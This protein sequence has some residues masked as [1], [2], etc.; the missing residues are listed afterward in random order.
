[1]LPGK[2]CSL[3]HFACRAA[4]AVCIMRACFLALFARRC[5]LRTYWYCLCWHAFLFSDDVNAI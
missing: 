5:P 3:R 2:T 4:E 1:M